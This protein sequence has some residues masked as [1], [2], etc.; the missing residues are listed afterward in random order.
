MNPAEIDWRD[1]QQLDNNKLEPASVR[2]STLP[3]YITCMCDVTRVDVLT[4]T[5]NVHRWCQF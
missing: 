4:T 2:L 5:L 3:M 1:G